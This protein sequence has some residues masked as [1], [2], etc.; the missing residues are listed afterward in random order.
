[1][2]I[3]RVYDSVTHLPPEN[4][5]ERSKGTLERSTDYEVPK[6]PRPS[7]VAPTLYRP[8]DGLNRAQRR[9]KKRK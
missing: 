4:V 9:A 6:L 5:L 8:P 3:Q 2:S 7:L 1:M